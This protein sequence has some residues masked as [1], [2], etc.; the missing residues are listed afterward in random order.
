MWS[1]NAK[2]NVRLK[3]LTRAKKT[4]AWPSTILNRDANTLWLVWDIETRSQ[5]CTRP[6]LHSCVIDTYT[7]FGVQQDKS[8]FRYWWFAEFD[9]KFRKNLKKV[10]KTWINPAI[11]E[12]LDGRSGCQRELGSFM[13]DLLLNCGNSLQILHFSMKNTI[14]CVFIHISSH[15]YQVQKHLYHFQKRPEINHR[16]S[17]R[18]QIWYE[19]CSD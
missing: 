13:K 15:L 3:C 17:M 11:P 12:R 5:S 9:M 2:L 16:L 7:V 14:K 1:V 4:S 10:G 8:W 6:G 18:D 19:I